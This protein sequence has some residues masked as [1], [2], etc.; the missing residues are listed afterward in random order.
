MEYIQLSNLILALKLVK[1]LASYPI[2]ST[3][4]YFTQLHDYIAHSKLD[5]NMA[6]FYCC[7][8]DFTRDLR[9]ST[10]YYYGSLYHKL[11]Y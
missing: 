3:V 11:N 7:K 9:E 1:T 10:A 8:Q 4:D 6:H 2:K 5:K